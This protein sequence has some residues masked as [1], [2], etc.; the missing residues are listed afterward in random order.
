MDYLLS[1]EIF[2][3]RFASYTRPSPFLSKK[4]EGM[5]GL[6]QLFFRNFSAVYLRDKSFNPMTFDLHYSVFK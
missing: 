6:E 5:V 1:R 4:G 3:K 2:R